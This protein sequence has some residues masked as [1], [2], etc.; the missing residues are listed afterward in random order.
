[1]RKTLLVGA[2]LVVAAVVVVMLGS[3]LDLELEAIALLGVAAGAV[4]ALVPDRPP[5]MRLAGFVAGVV[6]AW[7]GFF[8]RAGFLPDSVGGRAVAVGLVVA[9]AVGVTAVSLDRIPLW[10]T[11]LGVAA[12][13]GAYEYTYSAAPPEVAST[14][15]SAVTALLFTAAIG[16]LATALAA[17]RGDTTAQVSHRRPTAPRS[18]EQTQ[19]LD[20]TNMEKAK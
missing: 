13:A 2:V 3:A 1:M 14:S 8:V 11:L 4:V 7:I 17:P 20:E 15:V 10:S 18:E 5:L 12:L 6:I 19:D 16:F 9:L